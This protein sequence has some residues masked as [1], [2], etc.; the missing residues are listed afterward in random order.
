MDSSIPHMDLIFLWKE[1]CTFSFH[2]N[3]SLKYPFNVTEH[4]EYIITPH[5]VY[6]TTGPA[7]TLGSASVGPTQKQP[8]VNEV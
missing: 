6:Q 1:D 4:S 8:T 2:T 5:P 7:Q 3:T